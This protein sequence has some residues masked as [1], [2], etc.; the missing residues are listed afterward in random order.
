MVLT[1]HKSDSCAKTPLLDDT[2]L[3]AFW[4]RLALFLPSMAEKRCCGSVCPP[5]SAEVHSLCHACSQ[6]VIVL[7]LLFLDESQ[8]ALMTE[9]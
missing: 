7:L 2:T 3:P 9:I 8:T 1:R 5:V 4:S 6:Y